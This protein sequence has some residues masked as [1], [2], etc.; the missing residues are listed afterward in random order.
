VNAVAHV[1]AGIST[2]ALLARLHEVEH[3]FGRVRRT[4]NEAR[5][6][7]LDLLDYNGI[8]RDSPLLSLPHPRLHERAFVL[9]PL[10]DV[11][12][13]WCHPVLGRTAAE[14][15]DALPE[16]MREVVRLRSAAEV[17][18]SPAGKL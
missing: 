16:E 17:D 7:D 14:L 1:E 13:G 3:M 4:R 11:A 10:A 6:L 12:P 15:L 5:P 9:K 2:E 18:A 8:L